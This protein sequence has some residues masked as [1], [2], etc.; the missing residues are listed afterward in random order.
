VLVGY[1][2]GACRASSFHPTP[3]SEVGEEEENSTPARG[4]VL[5]GVRLQSL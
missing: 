4:G 3:K 2:I 1:A 5:R